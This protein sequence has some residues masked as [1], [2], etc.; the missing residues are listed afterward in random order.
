MTFARTM[1]Q[2]RRARS[3]TRAVQ[4]SAERSVSD[5]FTLDQADFRIYRRHRRQTLC[6]W[7]GRCERWSGLG[8]FA[9]YQ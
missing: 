1:V 9:E 2:P 4:C 3:S 8:L 5:V 7:P 6:L